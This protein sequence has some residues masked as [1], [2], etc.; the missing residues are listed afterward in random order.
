M[1]FIY[2]K[3]QWYGILEFELNESVDVLIMI[4]IWFV[5][6]I[7]VYA[8]FFSKLWVRDKIVQMLC[9]SIIWIINTAFMLVF[10][11]L[12]LL[13]RYYAKKDVTSRT[14]T[15]GRTSRKRSS[16][17]NNPIPQIRIP[18]S[19]SGVGDIHILNEHLASPVALSQNTHFSANDIANIHC[20]L[21]KVQCPM[22]VVVGK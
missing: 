17:K 14:G 9:I 3:S 13:N 15:N 7:H 16:H 20:P 18:Q 10:F 11:S 22:S 21:A 6:V 4:N 2:I 8:N 1:L 5:F 19:L 12:S